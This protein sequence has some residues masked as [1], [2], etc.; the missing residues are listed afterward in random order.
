MA[1][2]W[3]LLAILGF[4]A[5]I[6][7]A[8]G[9]CADAAL[10]YRRA[11][12]CPAQAIVVD[13]KTTAVWTGQTV[14]PGREAIARYT[15]LAGHQHT[16]KVSNRP[17]GSTVPILVS[18]RKPRRACVDEPTGLGVLLVLLTFTAACGVLLAVIPHH[19]GK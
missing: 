18:P 15:D 19:P 11:H 6:I 9:I 3:N 7:T 1:V 2:L 14:V 12:W 5:A 4:L 10:A 16:L 8:I 13:H 17:L